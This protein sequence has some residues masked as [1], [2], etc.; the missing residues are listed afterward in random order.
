LI[1]H[2]LV[3]IGNVY[4][5]GYLAPFDGAVFR[6]LFRGFAQPVPDAIEPRFMFGFHEHR[7]QASERSLPFFIVFFSTEPTTRQLYK[8]KMQVAISRTYE[9]LLRTARC[10]FR[11][12]CIDR[13]HND[14]EFGRACEE[15]LEAMVGAQTAIELEC[16]AAA[17]GKPSGE[18]AARHQRQK[19]LRG[20]QSDGGSPGAGAFKT[21]LAEVQLL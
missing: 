21:D 20:P 4:F 14:V 12:G 10:G 8:S 16:R 19:L 2:R 11:S 17:T 13:P 6:L 15:W 3:A 5:W 7:A 1:H 9:Y 18:F